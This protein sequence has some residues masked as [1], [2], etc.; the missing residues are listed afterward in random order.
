MLYVYDSIENDRNEY[1]VKSLLNKK[2]SKS[3]KSSKTE[4]KWTQI[5]ENKLKYSYF[6]VDKY[7]NLALIFFVWFININVN[8]G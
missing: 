4:K 1:L 6:C 8:H 2:K 7:L 3:S 5:N